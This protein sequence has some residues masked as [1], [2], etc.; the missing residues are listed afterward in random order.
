[1]MVS[2]KG[3]TAFEM[4]DGQT[5]LPGRPGRGAT[6]QLTMLP[7]TIANGSGGRR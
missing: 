7:A 4:D 5:L 2:D 3:R 1:V 6:T